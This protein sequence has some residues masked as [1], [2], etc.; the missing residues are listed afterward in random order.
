MATKVINPPARL[1]PRPGD[2]EL[3]PEQILRFSFFDRLKR[4][5]LVDKFPGALALRRYRPGEEIFREGEP[6]WTAFSVLTSEDV[7]TLHR[8]LLGSNADPS[9]A[10]A[11]RQE[12]AR[13]EQRLAQ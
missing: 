5:P 10:E 3:P 6:G 8:S 1:E 13:G 7:L 4:K 2:V 9:Q 12:V 11:L